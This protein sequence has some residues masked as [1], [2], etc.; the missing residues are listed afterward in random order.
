[1]RLLF[2]LWRDERGASTIAEVIVWTVII[3]GATTLAGYALS[4]S[5]RGLGGQVITTIESANP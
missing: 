3:V 1:M 4:A 2:A 5:I